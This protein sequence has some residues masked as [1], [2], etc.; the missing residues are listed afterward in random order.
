MK[1]R[2]LILAAALV[3][4]SAPAVAQQD[5]LPQ[6]RAEIGLSFAPLVEQTAP[7]V[8]NIYAKRM[9]RSRANPLLDDPFF[10]RFFGGA[11][12]QR[13]REREVPSLGSGVIVD[14]D[15]LV[16][17]NAHVIEGADDITVIL[18]D[19]REFAA[20]LILT[21][22]DT[23]LAVLRIQPRNGPLPFLEYR[24]ADTLKVGDLVL[25]IGNPFGVGQTVT[26][27]IVSG[28]ARSRVTDSAGP[29]SFIQTDAAVNP[30]NSGG[31]LV[32][33][34]GRLA[35]INTAIFTRSG[36]SHGVGFAIP[37]NLVRAVVEGARTGKGIVRAWIG[38]T[39]QDLTADIADGLGRDRP[40]G[41]LV[42]ELWPDGPADRAGIRSG[43][44]IIG[45][46]GRP[47]RSPSEF[48]FR[49]ATRQVGDQVPLTLWRRGQELQ[50]VLP[51][52][53]APEDPPRNLTSLRGVHPLQGAEIANLSPALTEELN[54]NG[55]ATG[56]II[57][58]VARGSQAQRFGARP[59]DVILTVNEEPVAR[60]ED[61]EPKL[62][63]V[64][65]S[66]LIR[67][68]R[69]NG[70]FRIQASRNR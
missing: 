39:G 57:L 62:V 20:E 23:D 13:Q 16:V 64:Q 1:L 52:E 54:F 8:V 61:V 36:G 51:L 41:V 5:R 4:A 19:R 37:S 56:V 70:S 15:G 65:N 30:G 25:A 14:G 35:G 9:V 18:N 2:S 58:N 21:D 55:P 66:W 63:A 68:R 32:T 12:G 60:V 49:L 53:T 40:G 7:A 27:G 26:S 10:R 11:F 69:A 22:T 29:Q 47:V 24:D 45:F 67:L 46:D 42:S 3:C 31:A 6:S 44:V 34:D 50:A 17:T 38:M 33:L 48:Q 59:G 28:L 43:D